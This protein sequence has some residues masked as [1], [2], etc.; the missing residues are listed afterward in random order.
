MRGNTSFKITSKTSDNEKT[1]DKTVTY[2]NEPT[3]NERP[4]VETVPK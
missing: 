3:S 1:A 2:V 4:K